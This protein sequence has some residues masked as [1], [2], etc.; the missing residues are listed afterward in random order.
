MAQTPREYFE[1]K[2]EDQLNE[3]AAEIETLRD[4]MEDA[5]WE[6]KLDYEKRIEELLVH[7]QEVK[8]EFEELKVAGKSA[9]RA[10]SDEL[11]RSMRRFASALECASSDLHRALLE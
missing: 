8:N 4:E 2:F 11:A 10:Q 7:W 6:P 9:W 5:E 3:Y 1:S